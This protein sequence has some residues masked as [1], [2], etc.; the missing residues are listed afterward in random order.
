MSSNLHFNP[1]ANLKG[2]HAFLSPSNYYW[3]RYTPE[4]T[5][6]TFN[7]FKNTEKGIRQHDLAKTLIELGQKLPSRPKTTLSLYVNDAIMGMMTPEQVLY[8]S[9]Y[10]FGTADA[11]SFRNNKLHIYDLK[12]GITPA[13]MDQVLIYAGIFCLEYGI[14][15]DKIQADLRIYQFDQAVVH[16]PEQGELKFICDRIRESSKLLEDM[17]GHVEGIKP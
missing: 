6:E 16:I 13:C 15:P 14:N 1:H 3:L 2:K 8:Y 11:I 5:I 4:K 10:C 17:Y 7:N 9:D 12:T